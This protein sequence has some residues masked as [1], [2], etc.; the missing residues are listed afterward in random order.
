MSTVSQNKFKLSGKEKIKKQLSR[1]YYSHLILYC[2]GIFSFDMHM[3][4][5][6]LPSIYLLNTLCHCYHNFSKTL[7]LMLVF[8]DVSI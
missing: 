7:E 1:K 8:V 5:I 2:Y 3:I 6:S 4:E